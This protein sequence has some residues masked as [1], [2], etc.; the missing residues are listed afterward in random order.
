MPIPVELPITKHFSDS[1]VTEID[2]YCRDRL[3]S[4]KMGLREIREEKIQKWRKVWSGEPREKSKSF[5]W[6]GA[7][8]LVIQVVGSY[9]SQLTAKIVMATIAADPLWVVGLMGEW[10]REEHSEEQREAVEEW[11]SYS[12]MEPSH[13]NLLD[14]YVVWIRTMVKYGLGAMKLLPE[15]TVEQVAETIDSRGNVTFRERTRHDGPVALPLLF[16]DFL[17]PPTHTELERYPIVAQRKVFQRYEL[18]PLLYDPS[19][20]GGESKKSPIIEKILRSPD[21]QGPDATR[22]DI[23]QSTGAKSDYGG[24]LSDEWDIYE[25]YF[26]YTVLGKRFHIIETYHLES[27]TPLK[28]V[29][30]WLPENTLPYVT[31]RLGSDGERSHGFGFCE[32][33]KDYQEEVSAIH[34]RRGDASTLSNTNLIRAG[35]GTQLDSNFSI[36]PNALVTGAEGAIEVIPLG[37]NAN[38]TIKDEQ[39][40]LNL[41]TDRA[42]VGPSASGAGAG[43][44]GKKGQ[45]SAMGAFP[46]LQEG[47]TRANLNVTEFRTSHY[48]LGRK[49]LLY[50]A[51]FGISKEHIDALGKQGKWLELALKNY[52]EG[53]INLPIRAATGSVNKE[54]EKQN[55]MLLLNNVRAHGQQIAQLLQALANPMAPPELQHFL[56]SFAMSSTFLM[57]RICKDFGIEDPSVVVPDVTGIEERIVTLEKQIAASKQPQPG[58]QPQLPPGA[59]QPPPQGGAPQLPPPVPAGT[60]GGQPK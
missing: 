30:N 46:I 24:A 54:I 7:A 3:K 28:R 42:G 40:T 1:R 25:S 21:R 35:E 19:F 32:M 23:E 34:N 60:N 33:L 16:E 51:H 26:P 11:L 9:E 36:Y 47:N 55:L 43:A 59:P 20:G 8:N 29:F 57:K 27:E 44:P 22:R 12:G 10:K 13:L 15:L 45:F 14:K 49:K 38:E 37:R 39:Q 31:A 52:R 58:Q 41:A 18:E 6:Q 5:P 56:A 2:V 53:R 50:D 17:I 4:M 48:V